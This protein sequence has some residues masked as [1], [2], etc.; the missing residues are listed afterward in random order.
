[1]K[2]AAVG[3][4]HFG[5]RSGDQ[6][7]LDFQKHWFETVLLQHCFNHNIETIIQSGD[8]FDVRSHMKTNV[9]HEMIHWLPEV[10][11]KY[12]I[13]RLIIYV[14]NHDIFYRDNNE[15]TSLDLLSLIG[16]IHDIEI[17]I[18]K[19]DLTNMTFGGK[20]FAFCPWI[21][22]NNETKLLKSMDEDNSDYLFGHFDIVNMP[23]YRGVLAD[24]GLD[25]DSFNKFKRV[26][27]GHYHT[28]S[29][30]KNIQ[31]L[32]TPIHLT[33]MDYPDGTERGFWVL[34]T[35]EDSFELIRN[36]EHMTMFAEI[37]YDP[38]ETYDDASFTPFTGNLVKVYVT[39]N[40]DEKHF[41]KF[42]GLLSKAPFLDYK[43]IDSTKVVIT[44]AEVSQEALKTSTLSSITEYID[45]QD[46]LADKDAVKEIAKSIYLEAMNQ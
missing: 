43:I 28:V 21:N 41:K 3:D 19:H 44:R 38:K 30:Y 13:K 32:G 24:H 17:T 18:I 15:V 8:W 36:E 33:W 40:P 35:D 5:I 37:K 7:F 22:K 16:E 31:Y 1:M 2:I 27:S 10:L 23:M 6:N 34:D 4:L 14:G 45:K 42:T 20:T 46:E 39:E 12:G 29:S 26:I 11:H 25:P 9:M